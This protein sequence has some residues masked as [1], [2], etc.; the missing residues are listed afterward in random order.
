MTTPTQAPATDAG[1]R[2]AFEA[3]MSSPPYERD[4]A[5]FPDN[6]TSAW[7]GNYKAID[8]DLAW[9]A[10]QVRASKAAAS[11]QGTAEPR[12][13]ALHPTWYADNLN[14]PAPQAALPAGVTEAMVTAY[15]TAN[16]AYW[17]KTDELPQ[18]NPGKWRNGT[19]REA[20]RVSLEAALASHGTSQAAGTAGEVPAEILAIAQRLHTQ[21][22]RITQDPLF[23]VQQRRRIWG[24]DPEYC[25]NSE[26]VLDGESIT[27]EDDEDAPEGARK[28]GYFDKWEFVTGCFTEQGC[29]DFITCNGHNLNEPRIYAYG[30][31]R[32]AEFI[33]LRKWLMSLAAPQ[34]QQATPGA[35]QGAEVKP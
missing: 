31:Y 28:V 3:F 22:N 17:H 26:W 9:C 1:E 7:P 18:E 29:K 4:V 25:D 33:A 24:V 23:A 10:W 11:T 27:L 8:I 30:S 6:A 34:P 14:V 5:R 35:P 21:D 13:R 32:N 2:E 19:P 15:L 16:D 20:T 12:S